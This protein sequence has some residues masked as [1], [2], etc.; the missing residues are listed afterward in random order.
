MYEYEDLK[1]QIFTDEGQRIFLG[2]RDNCK[3]LI[4]KAGAARMDKIIQDSYGD[5]WFMLACVDRLVELGE[6]YE[7]TSEDVPSQRRIFTS[8][9]EY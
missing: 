5:T 3:S 4:N 9:K 1:P 8:N 6:I 2:I 7:I